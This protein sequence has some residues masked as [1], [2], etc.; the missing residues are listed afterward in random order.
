MIINMDT[1]IFLVNVQGPHKLLFD[2]Q[3]RFFVHDMGDGFKYLGYNLKPNGY[4][5]ED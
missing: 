3:Q 1:T 5:N 4:G 2:T